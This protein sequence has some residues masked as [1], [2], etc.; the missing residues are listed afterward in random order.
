MSAATTTATAAVKIST[1]VDHIWA[2]Y[3][4]CYYAISGAGASGEYHRDLFDVGAALADEDYGKA[5]ELALQLGKKIGEHGPASYWMAECDR[6]VLNLH[7][8][9]KLYNL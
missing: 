3:H 1:T 4:K 2:V 7:R 5:G 8:L 6:L 9:L